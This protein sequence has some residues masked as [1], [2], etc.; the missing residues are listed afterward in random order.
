MRIVTDYPRTVRTIATEWITLSDGCRLAARIWLPEDAEAAPVPAIFEFLPYRLNDGTAVRDSHHFPYLAGHGYAGV[1]V[2]I[3]GTGE[4]DGLLCDEY[5]PQEQF[6]ACEV[7]AWIAEQPWCTGAVGMIGISWSGF[8]AL[9]VAARRPPALKAIVTLCSTDDRYADDVHY[10]GGCV[11]SDMLQWASSMLG[12]NGWPPDPAIVGE[13]W[14]EMWL[15]RLGAAPPFIE[16]WL[17]HQRRDDYWKQGSVCEDYA[18][19]EAAVYAVGGW[20]DG[21][22]NAIPRLLEGLPGARKGLIGPWSHAWPQEGP[23]GPAIGF[24]QELLRWFD[25]WLGGVDTGIMDEPMLRAYVQDSFRPASCY[26]Q[27]P[28]WWVAEPAWPAPGVGS[29]RLHLNP[30]GLAERPADEA[31]LR[32]SGVQTAGLDA[33]SWCPYGEPADWPGDQRAMDG[34]SL[35]FT[36]EPLPER[37]EILG[38]PEVELALASDRPHALVCVRLCEVFA[39]GTSALVT[40]ALQNLTHR[41]G[42]EHPCALRPGERFTATVKLDAIGH[43]FAPGSRIRLGISPTYWPWAWPSPEPVT[44]TLAAGGASALVLP[45]REPQPGDAA[46]PAFAEPEESEPLAVEVVHGAPA[47][48]SVH[49]DLATGRVELV[50]DWDVGGRTRLPNGLEVEDSNRTTFSIVEGDPLSASVRCRTAGSVGRGEWRTRCETESVMTC[51]AE[52]FH[53]TVV[54]HA[55]EGEACAFA[56]T[57]TFTFPRDLV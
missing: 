39:D 32:F 38:F 6:D 7:I 44:L 26:T 8:N 9:Q 28:G 40:R 49:R 4:S 54:V 16:P 17:G 29:L 30:D 55:Y 48:R 11:G 12:W 47:G 14:R 42:D 3:R 13:R 52:R 45:V 27:R 1:R 24:L 35:T 2:D 10:D 41:E 56:K 34:M 15:Q 19:I 51:D 18:S 46:L 53:V 36:S 25:H 33:G 21:Y 31:E 43:A 5:L 23:P 57:W 22:T 37:L 50:Y 20:S